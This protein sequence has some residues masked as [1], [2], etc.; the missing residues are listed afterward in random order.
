M[1]FF[2]ITLFFLFG[3]LCNSSICLGKASTEDIDSLISALNNQAR[4][5]SKDGNF[6]KSEELLL[7]V[8]DLKMLYMPDSLNKLISTYGNLGSINLSM[9]RFDKAIE[10]FDKTIELI[11]LNDPDYKYKYILYSNI[12][13]LYFTQRDYAKGIQFFKSMYYDFSSKISL[14]SNE[15]IAIEYS[16]LAKII[17]KYQA[18]F[19]K[20]ELKQFDTPENYIRKAELLIPNNPSELELLYLSVCNN[21]AFDSNIEFKELYFAKRKQL[22]DTYYADNDYRRIRYLRDYGYFEYYIKNNQAYGVEL[23]NT[24][25]ELTIEKFGEN[26]YWSGYFFGLFSNIYFSKGN[27][28]VC[29]EFTQ[30]RLQYSLKDYRKLSSFLENPKAE[31][32][33]DIPGAYYVLKIKAKALYKMYLQNKNISYLNASYSSAELSIK[34]LE[35]IRNRI[36]T[37]T[38]QYLVSAKEASIYN[39]SQII[40]NEMLRA[41]GDLSYKNASFQFNEKG[42]AFTLLSSLRSKEAIKFGDIPI[43][44]TKKESDLNQQISTYSE[45]I[46]EEKEKEQPNQKRIDNWEANLFNL[47]LDYDKLIDFFEDKYPKYYELKYDNSVIGISDIQKKLSEDELL[48]E[49]SISDTVLFT[50]LIRKDISIIEQQKIDSSLS[51][52]CTAFYQTITQQSFSENARNSFKNYTHFGH[53]IYR[54]LIEPYEKYIEGK[55]LIIIP[56]GHISYVPFDALLT[57]EVHYPDPEYYSLPYMI[58]QNGSSLSYSATIH[59]SENKYLKHPVND[60]LAFAP[61]YENLAELNPGYSFLRQNDLKKLRRIPGV[62]EEV[63]QISKIL[64]AEVF[65]DNQATE[66]TFKEKA[67]DYKVLHL[68]MHTLIDD[69]NPLYSK[70]AF[71]QMVDTL[72]D[73]F[74]HTYEIYNMD[75]NADLTVLSSCNTGMGILQKGEGI[76]SLARGFTY[77]GCPSILMTLWEVA[78]LSTVEIMTQFYFYLGQ[79]KSKSESLRLA[80]IDYLAHADLLKSNPFFWSSFV[81]MGDTKAIYQPVPQKY[82]IN[83]LI[84]LVPVLIILI[85]YW[86]Y[87]KEANIKRS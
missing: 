76:Q 28:P 13:D 15:N 16:I 21:T 55:N 11:E 75:L 53:E 68:A 65:I 10:Y 33:A 32:I 39:F 64:D 54:V 23:L 82:I 20:E 44:L 36:D 61:D 40:C 74:L 58:Y 87:R 85:V 78:D 24:A 45:L 30:R 29:I 48:I 46:L 67:N 52:N 6:L 62:K 27:Y 38:S 83:I 31:E 73:G 59:F 14:L 5:F 42:K 4:D 37:E 47:Q 41:T 56:D 34:L 66:T 8:L 51:Q 18:Y 26:S 69:D 49:Y 22:L 71:T 19:T 77:A 79:G 80:K 7:K 84:L 25:Y 17:S 70:L 50:Y 3:L 81:I 2:R 9:L 1:K 72:N 57:E 35:K 43:E 63:R 86:R 60:I 12:S